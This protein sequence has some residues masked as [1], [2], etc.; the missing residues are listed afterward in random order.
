MTLPAS[1]EIETATN[2]SCGSLTDY[3]LLR[4]YTQA[5]MSSQALRDA[6]Y[7]ELALIPLITVLCP[8]TPA[9]GCGKRATSTNFV[10]FLV[11]PASVADEVARLVEAWNGSNPNIV[12]VGTRVSSPG[13]GGGGGGTPFWVWI[14]VA[15]GIVLVLGVGIGVFV[16]LKFIRPRGR[17]DMWN[18]ARAMWGTKSN[19]DSAAGGG[20]RMQADHD[21]YNNL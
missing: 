2:A 13:G 6:L 16:Y 19:E 10:D 18:S 8:A 9:F 15:V 21:V 17:S 14:I 4:I 20:L 5:C 3:R 12:V 7:D 1:W 11:S